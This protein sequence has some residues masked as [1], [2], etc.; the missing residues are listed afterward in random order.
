[1]TYRLEFEMKGLS[2]RTNEVL[3]MS[4]R[5]RMQ[6][7]KFWKQFVAAAVNAKK[8]K[9]PLKWAKVKFIRYSSQRPDFD[10][11]VS[12]FKHI[13]DGLVIAGIL[14]NDKFENIGDPTYR[15]KQTKEKAGKMKILVEEMTEPPK[16]YED[17]V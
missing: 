6:R 11:L 4:L 15:W 12:S 3:S 17:E 2:E 16:E 1:M 8:P 10:G 13:L 7:K 9:K 5:R 14:V